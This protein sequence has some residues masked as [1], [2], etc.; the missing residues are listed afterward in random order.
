MAHALQPPTPA[1]RQA[2]RDRRAARGQQRRDLRRDAPARRRAHPG[3]PDRLVRARRRWARRALQ[4][5]R[6]HGF[7]AEVA[8]LTAAERRARSPMTR[9]SSPGSA[10]TAAS[11]SPAATRRRSSRALAPAGRRDAA[12]RRDPRRPGGRRAGGRIERR[13]GDD[14][15]ADDPRRHLDRV[16]GARRDRGPEAARPAD[17][18]RPRLLS[19]SACVDQHFIKRGRL[20]RLVVAMADAG[21]RRGFGIDEN[22]AL[23]V[24]G[25]AARVCGEYGV[26]LVDMGPADG[27]PRRRAAS[28]T[29]G[30]A[31]STTATAS[32]SAAS[33]RSP[34]AAQAAGAQARDRLSRAGPLAAQRLRRLHAL[35]PDGPARARR[36]ARLRRRP[37]RGLRR[38]LRLSTSPSRSSARSAG[39]A[40][41][42]ATPESGLR[43]TALELPLL[44][45]PAEQLSATRLADR[46]GRPRA[47][48]R[49]D[50]EP[51]G[52]DRAARLLAAAS[53]DPAMLAP[54]VRAGR[55]RAGRRARRRLGRAAGDR[56]PSMSS[57]WRGS[58][59]RRSTSASPS[60]PST[61]PT[62]DAGPARDDRR[63]ARH[64]ALRRQPDPPGRDPAAPRRGERGA[65]R[66]RPR[67]RAAARR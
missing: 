5:F 38:A 26:M 54:P 27:R 31:T 47:H 60:T 59:C 20:G 42:I 33:G 9:R 66:H 58:A 15:A 35:R 11:I 21:V 30:S 28:A 12:P 22:T 46:I 37:G 61:T 50:A 39:R 32:T 4:V 18:H 25:G 65:A 24:E 41:L 43:M 67:P 56:A 45:A 53:A 52:A 1:G 17:G 49:H 64:P 36:P 8:P 3:L 14:V 55:R 2:R 44:D 10:P 23:L 63:P 29:S 57:C 48:L 6:S 16:G 34:G 7:E 62:Q 13:R 51:R 19:A 40:A